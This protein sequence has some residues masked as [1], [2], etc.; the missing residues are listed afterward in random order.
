MGSHRK[1]QVMTSDPQLTGSYMLLSCSLSSPL[2]PLAGVAERSDSFE[3]H[4]IL[5][6][7]P[8]RWR[9][10]INGP[11]L[12]PPPKCTWQKHNASSKRRSS[13][14]FGWGGVLSVCD[15]GER[16]WLKSILS[17]FQSSTRSAAT[18]NQRTWDINKIRW[19]RNNNNGDNTKD[20]GDRRPNNVGKSHDVQLQHQEHKEEDKN[21][22]K[23]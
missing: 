21:N 14:G 2:R 3:R 5:F 23:S 15:T 4:L 11:A 12:P 22:P 18:T 13:S 6:F 10:K 1:K 7:S 20:E 16:W 17:R 19:H 9:A 8:W